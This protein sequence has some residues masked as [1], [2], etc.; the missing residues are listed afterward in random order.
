MFHWMFAHNTPRGFNSK[1][2][3]RPQTLTYKED[4]ST[5]YLCYNHFTPTF[6]KRLQEK[7]GQEKMIRSHGNFPYAHFALWHK[8]H[9]SDVSLSL[10]WMS[11]TWVTKQSGLMS[12]PV[13][14][15]KKQPG[16]ATEL[17]LSRHLKCILSEVYLVKVISFTLLWFP[18][19]RTK[20][21]WHFK[22]KWQ[23]Y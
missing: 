15:L 13:L 1:F 18:A 8:L 4:S 12:G 6:I 17:L 20:C 2:C 10:C 14:H 7:K 3:A 11:H 21:F 5:L 23:C 22:T 16:L 9:E 19:N